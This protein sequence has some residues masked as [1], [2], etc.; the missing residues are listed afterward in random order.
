MK[1]ED[2]KQKQKKVTQVDLVYPVIF[3]IYP[4]W[5]NDGCGTR[6]NLEENFKRNYMFV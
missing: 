3:H 5:E 2:K 1:W 4:V 6:I